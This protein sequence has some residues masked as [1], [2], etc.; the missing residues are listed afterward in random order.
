[1]GGRE[2][3]ESGFSH[4]Q[5]GALERL[6]EDLGESSYQERKHGARSAKLHIRGAV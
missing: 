3:H 2:S 4:K 1:M 5:L 6:R